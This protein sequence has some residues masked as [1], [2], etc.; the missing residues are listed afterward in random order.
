MAYVEVQ[1]CSETW[2]KHGI[3]GGVYVGRGPQ[4]LEFHLSMSF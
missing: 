2:A 1:I 4:A 3:Q